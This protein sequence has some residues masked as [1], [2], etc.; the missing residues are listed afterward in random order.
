MFGRIIKTMLKTTQNTFLKTWTILILMYIISISFHDILTLPVVGRK[1]QPPEII[2]LSTVIFLLFNFPKI[3]FTKLKWN[4]LDFA[5]LAYLGVVLTSS[6]ISKN[7]RP[8]LEFFGLV[9][10]VANYFIIRL[11]LI[12]IKDEFEEFIKKG[13]LWMGL[14]A[15]T[16][17]ILGI[18]TTYFLGENT[19]GF[20]YEDYPY[21]GDTIRVEGF[22]STPHMLASILNV[23]IL[24]L[25]V[26]MFNKKNTQSFIFLFVLTLAYIFTFAKIVVLLVIGAIF[27]FIKK[28]TETI[29]PFLKNSL[30]LFSMLLF[31]F[32]MFATHFILIE[33]NNPNLEAI[34][35][36]AFNSGEII[37][38]TQNSFII[39]TTYTTLKQ[40][41]FHLGKKHWLTGVGSGNHGIYFHELKEEGLFPKHIPDYDPHSTFVGS[42]AETGIF[43]FVAILFLTFALFKMSN[44]L[45]K[46][47]KYYNLKIA[48][49]ACLLVSFMEAISVDSINFR[50][51][52]LIFAI[53]SAIYNLEKN[54]NLAKRST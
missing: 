32:Y 39:P 24:F 50:H 5:L 34:K 12:S 9:Y 45:L 29:N 49:A 22:T 52:W 43:G 11:Y 20:I 18:F 28:Q 13:I 27:I 41:A 14:L 19:L 47:K 2:F 30:R 54:Q 21:F 25:L 3:D 51:M 17:G 38:E 42:F 15:A 8:F 26:S 16:F 4:N 46:T 31:A 1:I 33:K 10:L 53:L 36:K 48:L 37:G 44:Q 40:S 35:E 7:F 6:F 23:S